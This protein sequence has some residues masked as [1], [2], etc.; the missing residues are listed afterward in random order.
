MLMTDRW[1]AYKS[2]RLALIQRDGDITH[3]SKT[4]S[5]LQM[6]YL[7][8]LINSCRTLVAACLRAVGQILKSVLQP[9]GVARLCDWAVLSWQ[10]LFEQKKPLQ[11]CS[12]PWRTPRRVAAFAHVVVNVAQ[13]LAQSQK[14]LWACTSTSLSAC[15]YFDTTSYFTLFSA[16]ISSPKMIDCSRGEGVRV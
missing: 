13:T 1:H 10:A 11:T 2:V 16:G 12:T 6:R 5:V 15:C 14:R 9:P 4:L 8:I 7:K 3:N